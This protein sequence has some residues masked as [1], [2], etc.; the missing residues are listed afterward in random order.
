[1]LQIEYI[2]KDL[3]RVV[4]DM[5]YSNAHDDQEN[6]ENDLRIFRKIV[7]H[8]GE[9]VREEHEDSAFFE[10][11]LEEKEEYKQEPFAHV[12]K[13]DGCCDHIEEF[14]NR[15]Q[16]R[17]DGKCI[18]SFKKRRQDRLDAKEDE[19]QWITTE[20]GHHVHLNEEGEPDKGNKHV[21]AAMSV[22][23]KKEPVSRRRINQAINDIANSDK[24]EEEKVESIAEEFKKLRKGTKLTMPDSWADDGEKPPTF[25]W[26][27]D[28]WRG[29]DG[30]SSYDGTEMAYYFLYD[31][32]NERPKITHVPRDPESVEK[33]R[34]ERESK[35]QYAMM[36]NGAIDGHYTNDFHNDH[37][38]QEE[39]DAFAEQLKEDIFRERGYDNDRALYRGEANVVGDKVVEEVKRRAALRKGD[40]ENAPVNDRPQVEDIYDVLR[41]VRDFGPP[42]GF[43]VEVESDLDKERT[44]AIVKEAMSRFPT[45]WFKDADHPP[46]IKIFDEVG[47]SC[48]VNGT[49]IHLFTKSSL[50]KYSSGEEAIAENNDRGLVN[51]LAHEL[52]HYMEDAN[53]KVGYSA[54]DCLWERGK[55]S[56]IVD[57][58][59][60]YKGYKDSFFTTYMGKI[61]TGYGQVT[62]ITSV[63]MENI[64]AFNPFHVMQGKEYDVMTGKFGRKVND[65]ES[66]GYILGVLAGL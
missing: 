45:D 63:L 64:G 55:D 58:E 3:L 8:L 48:C 39:R 19:G 50:G 42:E 32:E 20:N 22:G 53:K 14:R 4:D 54:R 35:K 15:R 38:S 11:E 28:V 6:F 43:D 66:L 9:Q 30:W 52:G 65:K 40:M 34:K 23:E 27:G 31:D 57:V 49:I 62:E 36:P 7:R 2:I 18:D 61:Y 12:K 51:T 13:E 47:R 24:S 26:D 25:V 37:V 17:K 44:D 60:G 10:G 5:K 33:S 41:D 29:N 16:K 1:M 59:P 46:I 21:V 56:E